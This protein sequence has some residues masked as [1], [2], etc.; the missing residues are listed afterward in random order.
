MF[1]PSVQKLAVQLVSVIVAYHETQDVKT[2]LTNK[3]QSIEDVA[4][5]AMAMDPKQLSK[6]L[7]QWINES[8]TKNPKRKD[9]LFLLKNYILFLKDKLTATREPKTEEL[10]E[11]LTS[12]LNSLIQLLKTDNKVSITQPFVPPGKADW[13]WIQVDVT[14]VLGWGG[15]CTSGTKLMECLLTP[16]Q[17]SAETTA[18][19][20]KEFVGEI[21][22]NFA[23][24]VRAEKSAPIEARITELEAELAQL[25][26]KIEVLEKQLKE[27]KQL[28]VS[29]SSQLAGEKETSAGLS[30]KLAA[31]QSDLSSLRKIQSELADSAG[32][33][34]EELNRLTAEVNALKA[35]RG[36]GLYGQF[37]VAGTNAFGRGYGLRD[38]AQYPNDAP[39]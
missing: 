5:Q 22:T 1:I 21:V 28:N 30:E 4:T 12:L 3:Q 34:T 17:L 2:H 6:I 11:K 8:T 38:E 39:S 19:K 27:A 7:D 13:Q 15:F 9:L 36:R 14:G 23:N 24:A 20:V 37:P 32:R 26:A 10:S 33:L 18:A 29:L 25:G 35:A 16:N 31:S